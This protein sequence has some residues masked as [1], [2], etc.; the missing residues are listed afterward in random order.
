MLL[1]E[2]TEFAEMRGMWNQVLDSLLR[3]MSESG[4]SAGSVSMKLTITVNR[5]IVDHPGGKRVANIPQFDYK[6][7]SNMP[8]TIT[9]KGALLIGE[10]ELI[11]ADGDIR[12]KR[13]PN[14]QMT[15]QDLDDGMD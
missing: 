11:N 13:V 7:T 4:S 5:V 14:A 8:Q 9:T 12:L 3:R 6:I 1:I 2:N 15:L 10:S